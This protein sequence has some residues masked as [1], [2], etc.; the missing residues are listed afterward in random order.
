MHRG[1]KCILI[2]VTPHP[3]ARHRAGRTGTGPL[4]ARQPRQRGL[5]LQA[6]P[7]WFGS[8]ALLWT[9]ECREVRY[10][11]SRFDLVDV[12]IF[13]GSE[14]S[15]IAPDEMRRGLEEI[16]EAGPD[17]ARMLASFRRLLKKA[18]GSAAGM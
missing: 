5:H 3:A 6:L 8:A 2:D 12:L 13:P 1:T 9:D 17:E 4:S 7:G 16:D 14:Q 10:D 15:Y 18:P 11:S